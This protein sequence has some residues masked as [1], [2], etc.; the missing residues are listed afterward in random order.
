MAAVCALGS[1]R[2]SGKRRCQL[3]NLPHAVEREAHRIART[4]AKYAAAESA[5]QH[6]AGDGEREF[7]NVDVASLQLLRPR[8]VGVEHLGLCAMQQVQF[9]PLLTQMGLNGPQRAAAVGSIIARM[10]APGS[11][12]AAYHWLCH[13]SA[14][15]DYSTGLRHEHDAAV[16]PTRW[17]AGNRRSSSICS[18]G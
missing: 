10:A 5:P 7:H 9:I 12:R 11:E 8:S 14:L 4:P 1:I 13:R 2:C 17:S 6:D 15:G 16:P 18:T 3:A